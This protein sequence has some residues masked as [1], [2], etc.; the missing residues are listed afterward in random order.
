MCIEKTEARKP[1][2]IR[3]VSSIP[4]CVTAQ[5]KAVENAAKSVRQWVDEMNSHLA[6][7]RDLGGVCLDIQYIYPDRGV[8]EWMIEA[9][10]EWAKHSPATAL[11]FLTDYADKLG[12][13]V[14]G[15]CAE[16][17]IVPS[18]Y[19]LAKELMSGESDV[20]LR[21]MCKECHAA[22]VEQAKQDELAKD[23]D[24]DAAAKE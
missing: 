23:A 17:S 4:S 2:G 15:I 21:E 14:C 11:E 22:A 24:A 18:E 7:Y 12:L 20:E 16:G 8:D 6:K 3:V 9:F 5:D 19:L 10:N 13:Q 1:T